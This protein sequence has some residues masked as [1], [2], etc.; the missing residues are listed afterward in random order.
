MVR[1][2]TPKANNQMRPLRRESGTRS[3]KATRRPPRPQSRQRPRREEPSREARGPKAPP[4]RPTAPAAPH[5]ALVPVSANQILLGMD[6]AGEGDHLALRA[7]AEA[8][9]ARWPL[10][11]R[12]SIPRL[13]LIAS[14]ESPIAGLSRWMRRNCRGAWA[15][16]NVPGGGGYVCMRD[17]RCAINFHRSFGA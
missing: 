15:L 1:D 2:T 13:L 16:V 5:A 4:G 7:S 12:Y 3:E 8:E 11:L 10:R 9:L 14:D 17:E 6:T